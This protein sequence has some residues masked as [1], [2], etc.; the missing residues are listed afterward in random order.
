MPFLRHLRH[1]PFSAR[2]G[3]EASASRRRRLRALNRLADEDP[4]AARRAMTEALHDPDPRVRR[5][6]VLLLGQT[7]QRAFA[8][9]GLRAALNDPDEEVRWAAAGVLAGAHDA[10]ALRVLLSGLHSNDR[11]RRDAVADA[12]AA[13][14]D[15]QRACLMRMVSQTDAR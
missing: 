12:L 15:R 10:R 13:L 2:A 9:P 3:P 4:G 11:A 8:E 1:Q 5:H 7:D 14:S 6:A